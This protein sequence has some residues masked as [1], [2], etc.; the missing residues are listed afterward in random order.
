[1]RTARTVVPLAMTAI[2]CLVAGDAVA[3]RPA[4]EAPTVELTLQPWWVQVEGFLEAIEETPVGMPRID[5]VDTLG[6]GDT[7]VQ[8]RADVR[9]RLGRRHRLLAGVFRS[10]HAAD[11]EL[12]ETISF[13]GTEFPFR[14]VVTSAVELEQ[15]R[16]LY[17]LVL[18]P[19]DAVEVGLL[20]GGTALRMTGAIA[21]PRIGEAEARVT[22]PAPL[23][24]AEVRLR[25]G[26]L[27][28]ELRAS[29][30][31]RVEIEELEAFL[32]DLEGVV[33]VDLTDNVSIVGGYRRYELD[34]EEIDVV[35]F[36]LLWQGATAGVR[37]RF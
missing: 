29:G 2:L 21:E 37:L 16:L 5:V 10:R 14:A 6:L 27:G 12:V 22:A 9:L 19:S 34:F 4:S 13:E 28:A 35:Q 18:L 8:G 36:G 30:F 15:A 1:M 7:E 24:G 17:G 23:V 25:S 20:F 32:L 3:Q 31:P 11:S 26:R 33:G